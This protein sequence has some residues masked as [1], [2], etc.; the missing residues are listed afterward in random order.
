M[1]S[2]EKVGRDTGPSLTAGEYISVHVGQ[3]GVRTG[4]S[5]W[6]LFCQE[7]NIDETG[8]LKEEED[9]TQGERGQ[10]DVQGGGGEGQHRASGMFTNNP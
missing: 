3:A 10:G 2:S 5:A 7:Q 9:G 4:K 8:K 6:E 1:L